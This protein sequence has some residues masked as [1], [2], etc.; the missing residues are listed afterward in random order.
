MSVQFGTYVTLG[1]YF[2]G[3]LLI[4]WYAYRKSTGDLEGYMLGGRG[5]GPVVTALSAGAADMSGWML[6]GLPGS[7]LIAGISGMWIVVGL[8]IGAYLNY[9]YVAPR[10]RIYTKVARDSITIPDFFENRFRDRSR[11]LK[12]ISAAVIFV[13][14]TFYT[15]SGM[16]S[17]GRFFESAF[18]MDY[19]FGLFLVTF[20][21]IAYTLFGGYLAVSL[22][23]SVQGLIMFAALVTIPAVAIYNLGGFKHTFDIIHSVDPAHFNILKGVKV[24]GIISLLAWGL[25]YFGQPHILV[26]FMSITSARELKTARRI[27]ISWMVIGLIGASMIGLVGFAYIHA[28]HLKL[29]DPETIFVLFSNILFNPYV[30]GILLAALLA[31]IMSTIS[32]QLLVTASAVTEDF[33]RAFLRREASDKEL[34][35][36]G[37]LSVLGI[38]LIALA[39][40]YS[41]NDTILN[42]VGYA[43]AGFGSSFG[44]AILLSLFWK[45]MNGW[46]AIAG[47]VIGAV[48]VILWVLLGLSGTLYEMIPAFA[49]S[50]IAIVVVS[51]LTSKPNAEIISEFEQT[52]REHLEM[53]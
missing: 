31:A 8:S 17:G 34:V 33:Y 49:A 46:G 45:R 27:G 7:V 37:R 44:P 3:M 50:L 43:W 35:R 4:G 19:R 22:T 51:L 24:L 20:I 29:D 18:G 42:L 41:P 9:V 52:K 36:V 12:L 16:V 47:I 48:T 53:V 6:M 23:D 2:I 1:I 11:L 15:S 39:M 28:N 38:A 26:R 13:F 10:L 30:T 25:G 21:V 5:V 14:F 32:S 40:S